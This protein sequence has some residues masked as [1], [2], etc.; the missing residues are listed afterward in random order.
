MGLLSSQSSAQKNEN[1][2][3]LEKAGKKER[4]KEILTAKKLNEKDEKESE[5]RALVV[6]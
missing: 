5:T 2:E 3:N 6:L 4:K 1:G